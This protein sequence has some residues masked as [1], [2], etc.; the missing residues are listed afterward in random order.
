[1]GN[2][3]GSGWPGRRRLLSMGCH[4]EVVCQLMHTQ[5]VNKGSGVV[6]EQR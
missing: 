4:P 1:M 2:R 3:W 5:C 6:F